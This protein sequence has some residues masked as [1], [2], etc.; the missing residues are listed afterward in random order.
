MNF[1]K[2]NHS[3]QVGF[4]M[5][6]MID[7]VFL[8]LIFFMAAAVYAHW[9]KKIGITVP[10]SQT[11]D[12]QPRVAGEIIVNIERDGRFFIGDTEVGAERLAGLLRNVAEEYRDQP[13]IIRAD[14]KTEH[15]KVMQALDIC[16]IAGIWNIAFAVLPNQQP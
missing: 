14:R 16:R 13:I 7:V 10:T 8:L 2:N 1:R 5:A 11:Y 6:P 9:E 12:A 4:Q 3:P 15:A